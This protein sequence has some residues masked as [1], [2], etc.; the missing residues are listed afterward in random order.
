MYTLNWQVGFKNQTEIAY[1]QKQNRKNWQ[2][3]QYK[4]YYR[5]LHTD[6]LW[7]YNASICSICFPQMRPPGNSELKLPVRYLLK[8]FRTWYKTMK[9]LI[10][11]QDNHNS[12]AWLI[13]FLHYKYCWTTIILV[14]D[15][16]IFCIKHTFAC[17]KCIVKSYLSTFIE[18]IS[19]L[20]CV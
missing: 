1:E 6:K 18:W 3:G 8:H 14:L 7:K 4:G 13:Y 9:Q 10:T 19:I 17:T 11:L 5:K 2:K 15:W 20:Y 16:C 12:S